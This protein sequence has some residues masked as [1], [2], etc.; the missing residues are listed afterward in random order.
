MGLFQATQGLGGGGRGV[1]KVPLLKACHAHPKM[2]K[3]GTV[4]LI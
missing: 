3:L 4:I 1:K 2:M